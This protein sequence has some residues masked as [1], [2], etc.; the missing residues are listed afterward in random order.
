MFSE[1]LLQNE[2]SLSEKS[3]NHLEIIEGESDRLTRLI[4]NVLDFSKIEKGVKDYSFREVH[5]NKIVKSVIELMQYTLKMK[6]FYV[7][8]KLDDFNDLICGDADAITEAVENI[9]SN[10]I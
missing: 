4:N 3:K 7:T 10:A 6:G 1:M 2:K 8:T 5:F 9:I